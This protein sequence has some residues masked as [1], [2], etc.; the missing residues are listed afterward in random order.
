[1]RYNNVTCYSGQLGERTRSTVSYHGPDGQ[2]QGA[3]R[4]ANIKGTPMVIIL[5][6]NAEHIANVE[7]CLWKLFQTRYFVPD[8]GSELCSKDGS[9]SN[10]CEFESSVLKGFSSTKIV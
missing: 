9:K 5:D 4:G 1:M 8:S 3:L 10:L 6:G 7:T 2:A